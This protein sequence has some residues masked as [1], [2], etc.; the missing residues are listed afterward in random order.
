MKKNLLI[1]ITCT[2]FISCK[3][4]V[5]KDIT[6]VNSKFYKAIEDIDAVQYDVQN[7]RTFSDGEHWDNKGFAV[8]E[9]EPTDSIFGFHFYGI[10]NDIN[11]SAIYKD[12]IGFHISNNDNS[13]EM[14]EIGSWVIAKPGGQ[15]IQKGF[16]KLDQ[17]Y[18]NVSVIENEKSFVISYQFEDDIKNKIRNI[19]KV[20]ELDSNT[21]LPQKITTTLQ[22]E[23][24]DMQIAT[25][26]FSNMKTNENVGKSIAQYT[27]DLNTMD[28]IVEEELLPNPLLQHSLPTIELK[29]LVNHEELITIKTGQLTLIDFWEVWCG[30]CI[31]SFPK[32]EDLKNKFAADLNVIG[33]VSDDIPNAVK[34][35]EKK[36]A[37]FLNLIG[38]KELK[39]T[40]HITSF[41]RYFL[42]DKN[43][44]IQKEYFRFSDQI[45]KDIEELI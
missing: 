6:Y 13:F 9:L 5:K 11:K 31:A 15:M 27:Q 3:E 20:I 7:I 36:R 21:F 37:T 12:G 8:I 23:I 34:F 43:G 42:I 32:V 18:K 45:E 4:P 35:V 44:I 10:R 22:L 41:P 17:E 40:F 28:L 30:P 1:L 16:F 39:K 14:E 2:V 25:H 29:N 26:I 38:N 24:G 33:I 19:T